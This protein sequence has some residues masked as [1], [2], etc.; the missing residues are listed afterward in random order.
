M[1]DFTQTANFN[2][3]WLDNIYENI[4]KIEDYERLVREGCK[5]LLDFMNIPSSQRHVVIGQTQFQNLRF[6]VTEFKLLL[7]DLTPI[8]ETNKEEEFDKILTQIDDALLK[9]QLFLKEEFDVARNLVRANPTN[10][11]YDTINVLHK[12]KVDLF[13]VIKHILYIGSNNG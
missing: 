6:L 10:F 4:K 11:F 12:M 13:K 3:K 7:A 8:L 2:E 1:E 5:S 9:K